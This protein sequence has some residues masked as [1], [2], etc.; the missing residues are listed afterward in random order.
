MTVSAEQPTLPFSPRHGGNGG[1][2]PSTALN[3]AISAHAAFFTTHFM[4]AIP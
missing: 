3:L 1:G 2:A 4:E